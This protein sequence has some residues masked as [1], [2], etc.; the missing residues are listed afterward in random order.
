M[1]TREIDAYVCMYA[2][3]NFEERTSCNMTVSNIQ[4]G[5]AINIK[6]IIEI[7]ERKVEITESKFDEF[8][9]RAKAL[10]GLED[11]RQLMKKEFFRESNER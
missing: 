9:D 5:R 4:V 2:L 6:M 11:V 3:R 7:P 1:K 10:G 8:I